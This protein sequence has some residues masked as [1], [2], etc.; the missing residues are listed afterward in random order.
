MTHSRR[1]LNR[2]LQTLLV[3]GAVCIGAHAA[4][5]RV[6]IDAEVGFDF[7]NPSAALCVYVPEASRA[8]SDC[9]E[10]LLQWGEELVASFRAQWQD[11]F[12]ALEGLAFYEAP[13]ATDPFVAVVMYGAGARLDEAAIR[14]SLAGLRDGVA[15]GGATAE[16]HGTDAGSSHDRYE[17]D[18]LSIVRAFVD[19]ASPG[20]DA[21]SGQMIIHLVSG[22]AGTLMVLVNPTT[23]SVRYARGRAT[24]IVDSVTMPGGVPG[25][26]PYEMGQVVGRLLVLVLLLGGFVWGMV[27]LLRR[28]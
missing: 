7:D 1:A 26:T 10:W 27:R 8:A 28:K 15:R 13:G 9:D 16:L 4:A 21:P 2:L 23:P 12:G 22:A 24:A 20:V 19:F 3:L 18:G 14:D 5:E 25:R 6:Q 17:R 11:G